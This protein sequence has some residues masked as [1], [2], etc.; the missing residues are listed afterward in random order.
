MGAAIVKATQGG[1]LS[2]PENVACCVKHY[3]A[4]GAPEAGRDYN[5][6]E[7]SER[8][9]RE[10]YLPAYKACLDAGARLIMPSFNA[11]NGIP[12]VANR[13]LMNQVLRA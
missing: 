12:S 11:L 7:I 9:L 4:Y 5:T 8:M 13:W 2:D 3:A 1:D 6:V 10:T